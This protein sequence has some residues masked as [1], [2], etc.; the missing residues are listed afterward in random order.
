MTEA[1]AAA[2]AGMPATDLHRAVEEF[3]GELKTFRTDIHNRLIAQDTRMTMLDR[4]AAFRGRSPLSTDA[5]AEAPHQKAFAAYVRSGDEDALRGLG[6]E[7]K[8]ISVADGGFL[9]PPQV[10]ETVQSALRAAGSLRA[11]ANVVQVEGS[12][13]DVLVETG[14]TGT[15]WANDIAATAETAAAGVS[16]ITVPL[17]ELSAMPKA[18][19][20]LLDDAAFDVEAWLAERIADRFGR[21]EAAAFIN[22]DGSDKPRGLTR[23]PQGPANSNDPAQI[24]TL[25]EGFEPDYADETLISLVY[26]LHP[27]YRANACFVMSSKTAAALRR[28]KDADGRFLWADTLAQGEPARLLGYPVMISEDMP[29]AGPGAAALFFG[30]FRAGYTVAERPEL[31][32]LRDPFSA[33][34]HVLFYATKRVGGAVTDGRAIKRLNFA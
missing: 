13:Y 7:Q 8:A 24:G 28:M 26:A 1:R 3:V 20:R 27:A 19:Q 22:G 12:S 30:D 2:E 14:D 25:P 10:A 5:Q 34:P 15:A 18:S 17:H 16:R 11:I 23:V 9:M 21:A 6:V 32:V 4:K 31:R 29:E 33:K